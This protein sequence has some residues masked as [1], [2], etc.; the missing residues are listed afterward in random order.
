MVDVRDQA[1]VEFAGFDR[2]LS[3]VLRSG[4]TASAVLVSIGGIAYLND[5][6][7]AMPQYGG[8]HGEPVSL[9]TVLGIVRDAAALDSAGVIQLG[10][11][12]LIATPIARV[13]FSF[14]GFL[15]ERDRMYVAITLIVLMLL[16]A[17]VVGIK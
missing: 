9:R 11:L 3:L 14:F 16:V 4:V 2:W 10:L 6:S 15:R 1:S 13:V 12:V 17:S 5:R 7:R 8:F